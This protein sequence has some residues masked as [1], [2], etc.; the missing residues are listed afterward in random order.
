M[1][2]NE[3][4]SGKNHSLNAKKILTGVKKTTKL[5][6]E[7]A[8]NRNYNFAVKQEDGANRKEEKIIHSE[9]DKTIKDL[10]KKIQELK[11]RLNNKQQK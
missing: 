6:T 4:S 11:D 9:F 1:E 7:K 2:L 10:T 5:E 3:F 8:K